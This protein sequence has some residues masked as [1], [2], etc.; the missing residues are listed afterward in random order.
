[1]NAAFRLAAACVALTVFAAGDVAADDARKNWFD[2]PFVQATSSI[3]SCPVPE[4]PLLTDRER[5]AEAHWRVERGTSC[6]RSGRCR[7]PNSYLYDRELLPRVAQ[8]IRRDGRF[9]D[10][11][12]WIEGQRRWIFLKGCVRDRRQ[13]LE[14]ERAVRGVDDVEAVVDQL[15]VGSDRKPRYRVAAPER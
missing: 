6:F 15:L 12:V 5:R 11:S 7:L 13:A 14:L 1:M 2:D 8:F 10:T 4:G 9:D 3:A